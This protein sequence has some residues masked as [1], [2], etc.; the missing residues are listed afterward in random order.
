MALI[1]RV[2]NICL[3]PKTE[4]PVIAGETAT[5]GGLLTGYVL[6]L[7]AIGAIAGFIGGSVIG[8]GIPFVGG[9]FRTPIL[10]GAG[11]AVLMLVMAV[12]GVFI[13]SFIINALAP[14][15]GGEKNSGQAMKVAVYSYT[16]AWVAGI[17]NIIPWIGGFLALFGALY[18]LYL[19]FLGLPQLMKCPED[20]SIGY[21]VVVVI[22]AIVL[23]IVISILAACVGGAGMMA[24]GA[25]SGRGGDRYSGGDNVVFDKDSSMG[26]LQDFGKKMEESSK[27]MDAVQKNGTDAEKMAAAT[28][29]FGTMLGGGKNVEPVAIDQLKPFVPETFAGLPK[30]S[31]RAERTGIASM[32][33]SKAEATYGDD[34]G[35]SVSLDVSDTGG[36]SGLMGLASWANVQGE[37]EDQNGSEKTSKID[38]RMVH[39]KISK[40]SGG[41]NSYSLVLA[42][43]FMVNASGRGVDIATIKSAVAS[44]DL[45]KLES[46]KDVGVK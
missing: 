9:T 8:H 18:S 29:M 32:M 15:F 34:N 43:R 31:S 6:P 40:Q 20:K 4:W 30:K 24:S 13:L 1:D 17:F 46:M 25:L 35:K 19:L 28:A 16:A 39:E 11:L 7:A 12:V 41:T 23:S 38:G 21:T 27:K 5:T 14:S 36:M 44:L 33:V 10:M 3:T 22:C 26:K 37:K 2:K 45:K 42:D